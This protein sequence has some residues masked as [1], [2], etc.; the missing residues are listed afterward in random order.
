MQS[1]AALQIDIAQ[2]FTR[3]HQ[4]IIDNSDHAELLLKF[5]GGQEL[6]AVE[7]RQALAY[8]SRL[9]NIWFGTEHAWN[10]RLITPEF[11]ETICDDVKRQAANP[12][13]CDLAK[14]ILSFYP[15]SEASLIMAPLL[16]GLGP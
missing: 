14:R 7:D 9:I 8:V 2:S 10:L 12:K 11:Y 16:H 13:F 3:V 15:K 6:S 4:S 1:A 5:E